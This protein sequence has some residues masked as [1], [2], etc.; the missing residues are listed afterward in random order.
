MMSKLVYT[1]YKDPLTEV[2]KGYGFL[3]ALA[4]TS[5][6]ERLQ[7]HICGGLFV[8]LGIHV[9]KK[10]GLGRKEYAIRFQ[11]AGNTRLIGDNYRTQKA[12][13]F[14]QL[15]AKVLLQRL[16]NLR[17]GWEASGRKTYWGKS[18]EQKNKEGVCPDQLIQKIQQLAALQGS[19]PSL[20][21]FREHYKGLVKITYDTFG[22]WST[23]VQVAGLEEAARGR[24]PQYTKPILIDMIQR[25]QKV[26]GRRP[27][28]NNLGRELPS[29]WVFTRYFGNFSSALKEAKIVL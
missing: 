29:Q 16:E 13:E 14:G 1:P 3:G 18:L 12:Q 6:G 11:L 17:K 28:S 8:H 24:S 26:H 20:R 25:F 19:T 2:K 21:Q 10:H 22:S 23:A 7:C 27:Y 4:R 15:E 5:D 9:S